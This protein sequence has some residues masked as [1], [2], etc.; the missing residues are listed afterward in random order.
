MK[1]RALIPI[2]VLLFAIAGCDQDE[3]KPNALRKPPEPVQPVVVAQADPAKKK[4]DRQC[5]KNGKCEVA[6]TV[7]NCVITVDADTLAVEPDNRAIT[8][9]WNITGN[10]YVFAPDG[11]KFTTDG[12][13][14]EFKDPK[15][16]NDKFS[17]HDINPKSATQ[18]RSYKYWVKVVAK[19]SGVAC[20]TLDPIIVNDL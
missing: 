2:L 12:W 15:S 18:G 19:K 4:Y 17:W 10:D 20:P 13:E 3:A 11:I 1:V 7:N 5:K 16:N 6:V 8:I 14:K 9:T